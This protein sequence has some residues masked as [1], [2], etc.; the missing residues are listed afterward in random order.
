M[1]RDGFFSPAIGPDI[2]LPAMAQEGPAELA[3]ASLQVASLHGADVHGSVYAVK[4]RYPSP[5]LL[6]IKRVAVE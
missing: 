3:D 4:N 5:P 6:A 1:T 2:V